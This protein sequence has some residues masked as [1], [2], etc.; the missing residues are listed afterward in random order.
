MKRNKSL[1]VLA[2]LPL[3]LTGC[4]NK[5]TDS[6]QTGSNSESSSS[7]ATVS[8]KFN[9]V[10]IE[11]KDDYSCD[12]TV[13]LD[14]TPVTGTD[15]YVSSNS[16]FDSKDTKLNVVGS[17]TDYTFNYHENLR[18]FYLLLVNGEDVYGKQSTS[19]PTVNCKVVTADTKDNI[20]FSLL[21]DGKTIDQ[22]F[23][24][25]SLTVYRSTSKT[26]DKS[27]ATKVV[28]NGSLSSTYNVDSA[29]GADYFF[30]DYK[31]TSKISYTSQVFTKDVEFGSDLATFTS[32]TIEDGK[33]SLAGTLTDTLADPRL[34]L[35]SAAD[36]SQDSV[37][38]TVTGSSFS[39]S[40]D[41]T[42]LSDSIN[43]YQV[44]FMLGAGIYFQVPSFL[45]DKVTK[46]DDTNIYV[47]NNG[48]SGLTLTFKAKSGVN[49]LYSAIEKAADGTV[50]FVANGF[51]D[52]TLANVT[53]STPALIIDNDQNSVVDTLATPLTIDATAHT[54]SVVAPLG[55]L[56]KPGAWYNIKIWLD[57]TSETKTATYEFLK[58][59][60]ANYG[61]ILKDDVAK[62]KFYFQNY[63]DYLKLNFDDATAYINAWSYKK[64]DGKVFLHLEGADSK[65][66]DITAD[67]VTIYAEGGTD[68]NLHKANCVVSDK[69]TDGFTV[70]VPCDDIP[71][72]T[73]Y[74]VH[75][76]HGTDNTEI[77]NNTMDKP[78]AVMPTNDGYIFC[79]KSGTWGETS[80]WKVYKDGDV[81]K[82]NEVSFGESTVNPT[83]NISG[84]LNSTYQS[85]DLKLQYGVLADDGLTFSDTFTSEVAVDANGFFSSAADLSTMEKGKKYDIRL[86]ENVDGTYVDIASGANSFCGFY[87]EYLNSD[88]ASKTVKTDKGTYHVNTYTD[89]TYTMYLTLE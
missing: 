64:I 48:T 86:L 8:Y 17:G 70:D 81:A 54:F 62:K 15:F 68:D 85:K 59:D 36:G 52:E 79:V 13:K 21:N 56:S 22:F 37:E 83:F 41:I 10:T 77:T 45:T 66:S 71:A 39:F 27:T 5:G 84:A 76:V 31:I 42:K 69:E 38:A 33:L 65:A 29:S 60:A 23:L 55:G 11:V 14:Q 32:A 40:T 4:N 25:D 87:N 9:A 49:V 75:W 46:T 20:S 67:Y 47:L 58:A 12:F 1:I 72:D 89:G 74:Q 44:Y 43:A 7:S 30:L 82:A 18:D 34:L 6:S 63:N 3:V 16:K 73:K 24:S 53:L 80:W 88:Y 51:Y 50:S 78:N 35:S 2:L 57:T 19:L 26:L 61:T 28:E